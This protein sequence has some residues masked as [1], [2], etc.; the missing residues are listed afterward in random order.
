MKS[1]DKYLFQALDNYPYSLEETIESLDYALSYDD[2]NTMALCL[3]GRVYAEQLLQYDMAK[4]Y[5]QKALSINVNALEV[6]TYYIDTLL[7]NEDFEE[8]DK[9][10]D[11]ALKVKGSNKAEIWFKKV[12]LLERKNELK[13]AK[14]ALKEVKKTIMGTEFNYA[15]NETEKRLKEKLKLV[16]PKKK[17]KKKKE[18]KKKKSSK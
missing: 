2:K 16:S 5:F 6:H 14:K 17:K 9:L 7:L 11:F 10:I 15:I 13:Q 12:Q 3:Y 18:S 1:I 4:E 8:A